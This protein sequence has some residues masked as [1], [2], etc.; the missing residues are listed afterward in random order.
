MPKGS[1]RSTSS[2]PPQALELVS[3]CRISMRCTS[4]VTLGISL[5]L[6]RLAVEEVDLGISSGSVSSPDPSASRFPTIPMG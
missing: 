2:V 4:W 6:S 3:I 1:P 5:K